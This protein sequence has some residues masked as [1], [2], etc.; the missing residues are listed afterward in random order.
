MDPPPAG[1]RRQAEQWMKVA[2]KLLVANDLEGC[3]EFCSQALAA[4]R[5]T[6]GAEVLRAAADVLLTA[7]RRR[8]PNGQPDPYALLGIDPA[9][10]ASR[11]PDAVHSS[12]RRISL[13]LNRS[14]PDS[15]C[16]ASVAEAA[17]LVAGAW[18]FLS[19]PGL[20]SALDTQLD[21][22]TPAPTP[23]P[24]PAPMQQRQPQPSSR[25]RQSTIG[26]AHQPPPPPQP[27]PL[28]AAAPPPLP[29][30]SPMWAAPQPRPPPQ[31]SP[32]PAFHQPP[33]PQQSSPPRA[34][35]QPPARA[36]A[37]PPLPRQS[38]VRAA[39][40]LRPPP[41]DSPIPAAAHQPPPPPQPSPPRAAV[42]PPSE[43]APQPV[44]SGTSPSSPF[45]TL[46]RACSHIHQYDRIYEARKLKCSSCHQPF[47]AEAMA[48]TPPIVAGTDM[49]YCT[50]G[51]FPVGFPGCPGFE[52]LV[53]KQPQG[54][55]QLV[56]PWLGANGGVEANSD[57]D[58][59]NGTPV[60]AAVELPVVLEPTPEPLMRMR[61]EVPAAPSP[62]PVMPKRVEVPAAPEPVMPTR[63]EMPAAP[64]P[65][66]TMTVNSVK[67]GGKKRGRPKGSKNKK[68]TKNNK[69]L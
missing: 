43:A 49:Y 39:S 5:H 36:A 22:A 28:R 11:H 30:Q 31:Q 44:E 51:F 60:S 2:E 19:N 21:A 23:T 33:L 1:T 64:K 6:P 4:D 56:A 41:Q 14:H 50:W 26:A 9:N 15:P 27:T 67:V 54:A 35:P 12:Y 13:L 40:Q 8:I 29:Q 65:V 38:P 68:G 18:A 24:T 57:A 69:K 3:R 48:E 47:V 66:K 63:V 55:D 17:R 53:N 45:W 34:A 16:S 42:Q 52:N 20:K 32:I 61:V 58:V 10:P 46:C 37:P 62:E 59:Q 7:Q 25:P